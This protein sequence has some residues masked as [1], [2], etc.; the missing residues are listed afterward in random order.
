MYHIHSS[1][2]AVA[3]R[4]SHDNLNKIS[5]TAH[6]TELLLSGVPLRTFGSVVRTTFTDM[7]KPPI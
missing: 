4:H 6:D 7:M 2:F 5:A 1:G 3:T